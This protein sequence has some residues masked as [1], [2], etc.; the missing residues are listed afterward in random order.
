MRLQVFLSHNGV[1][2]RREA[3][4]LIQDGQVK[5]N[6]RVEWE[7][8]FDVSG[9]EDISV[10]GKKVVVKS[11]TYVML[12]KPP[13]YTTTRDDPFAD[14]IVLD[15]LPKNLQHLS[16]VGRLDKDSEGLLLMTNDGTWA[17]GLTHPKFHLDKTYVVH[18]HGKLSQ[19]NQ[20]KLQQ[21]V[22]IEDEKTA[23]CRIAQVRYNV[24]DTEFQITI[25]EGKKRQI[26]RMLWSVGH[27]VFFLKRISIGPLHLGSLTIGQYRE[28]TQQ[29]IQSLS[30]VT[31]NKS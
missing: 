24:A 30:T 17:Y 8:S 9:D 1:C 25:H 26:R 2:S 7:P 13:G 3:M 19:A 22:M 5:V 20:S 23:P 6:G 18:A 11:Y 21:G 16:P 27:K 28:L 12:H 15:L 14:K 31:S 10:D 29:E 4:A